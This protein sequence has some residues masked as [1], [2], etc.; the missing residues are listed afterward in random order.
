MI[1]T[2]SIWWLGSVVVGRCDREVAGSTPGRRIVEWQLWAS[3]SHPCA[4]VG[5]GGLVGEYWTRNI[6]VAGVNLAQTIC[7]QP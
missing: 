7:K 6:H 1:A 2:P 5:A 4:F 3:C